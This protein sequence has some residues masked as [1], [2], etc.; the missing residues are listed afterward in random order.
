MKKFLSEIW[1]FLRRNKY[2][3]VTV[4]F[5][6]IVAFLDQNNIFRRAAQKREI[7]QLETEIE[8]YRR[9]IEHDEKMLR[10]FDSDSLLKEHLARE[11][12]G[13]RREDEDVFLEKKP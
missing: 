9:Q 2:L 8:Q 12:Y 13:M 4:A 1:P 6:V 5:I 11:K 3:V 10:E 7:K